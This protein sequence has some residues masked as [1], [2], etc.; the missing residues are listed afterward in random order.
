MEMLEKELA[1]YESHK[2]E[3]LKTGK[4]KYALIK[5]DKVVGTFDTA[6][7][8]VH[9][10]YESFGLTAFLVKEIVEVDT[11]QNFTSNLIAA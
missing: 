6:S 11:P 10:G 1:T 8:A 4:G 7:D 3:L 5:D 2:E 9:Q